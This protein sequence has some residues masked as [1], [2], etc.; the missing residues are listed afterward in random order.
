MVKPWLLRGMLQ[1]RRRLRQL[2]R[3]RGCRPRRASRAGSG[4]CAS[5]T[6]SSRS[7]QN[8][9]VDADVGERDRGIAALAHRH[10]SRRA[11]RGAPHEFA[12]DERAR[13]AAH[14]REPAARHHLQERCAGLA[15][16]R[17]KVHVDAG[18]RRPRRLGHHVPIVEADD[19]DVRRDGEPI[20]R[21]ASTAPR[22]IWSLPQNSASGA[23]A[24][25]GEERL[26]RPR[27]PRPRT[28]GR[29]R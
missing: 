24:A 23:R 12:N 25:A 17:V 11:R 27:V 22:A 4:W 6:V 2:Q 15:A 16:E 20:S 1:R 18:Q 26:R 7:R 14:A 8:G 29:A 19:G 9:P 3:I 28:S 10:P 5:S 21:R 13:Q